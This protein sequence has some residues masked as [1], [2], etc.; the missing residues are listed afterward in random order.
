MS[1]QQVIHRIGVKLIQ[2]LINL[3]SILDLGNIFWRSQ[4]L[5]TVENSRDLFQCQRVLLNGQ[6]TMNCTD[7]I[8]TPQSRVGRK[9]I[10]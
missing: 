3:I 7:A 6:R 1:G 8:G 9:L 10:R 5:L 2:P 4:Y